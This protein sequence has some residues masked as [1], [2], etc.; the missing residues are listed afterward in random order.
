MGDKNGESEWKT[1]G[2]FIYAQCALYLCKCYVETRVRLLDPFSH[3]HKEKPAF[4]GQ[5]GVREKRGRRS[6][7]Q[8]LGSRA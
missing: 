5:C 7:K 1:T 6:E 2:F 3:F 4:L 8:P